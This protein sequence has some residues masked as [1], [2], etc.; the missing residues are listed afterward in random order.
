[1]ERD[2]FH[3]W[4][5]SYLERRLSRDYKEIKAN[6]G[7]NRYEFKGHYPDLILASHGMTLALME[8]ETED[9]LGPEQARRWKELAG[10]GPKLILMVP[11][12][13]KAKVADLLWK[14]GLAG[15]VS[16]ATYD[17]VIRM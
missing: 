12:H 6:V 8:V 9:T 4:M 15:K 3:D 11:A 14:E 10:L 16:I 2:F 1:M 17:V 7:E 13:T 5:V